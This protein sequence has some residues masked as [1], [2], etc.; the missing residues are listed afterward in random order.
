MYPM[1][2]IRLVPGLA[3]PEYM[4][5]LLEY[6]KPVKHTK[7]AVDAGHLLRINYHP[8]YIQLICQDLKTLIEEARR[9]S[10]RIYRGKKHIT[11]TDGIYK[12]RIY[13]P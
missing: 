4:A 8:P 11:I 1:R 7:K 6:C 12:A 5:F 10:L 9:R 2:M 13:T 3:I